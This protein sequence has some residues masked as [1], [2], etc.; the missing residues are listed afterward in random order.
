MNARL[1]FRSSLVPVAV[2]LNEHVS[3]GDIVYPAQLYYSC[4]FA[5]GLGNDVLAIADGTVH[6]VIN[7]VSGVYI[8]TSL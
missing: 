6:S 5:L 1:P 7:S 4:D 3:V 8:V 2:A